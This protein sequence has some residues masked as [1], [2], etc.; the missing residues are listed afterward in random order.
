MDAQNLLKGQVLEGLIETVFKRARYQVVP[1]G[2]EHQFPDI[3]ALTFSEYQENLPEGLKMLPDFMVYRWSSDIPKVFF[4]EVKYRTRLTKQSVSDLIERL[5]RQ[6]DY[7]IDTYCI[8]AVAEPPSLSK[9]GKV[10]PYHQNHFRVFD[11][12]DLANHPRDVKK[13]WFSG[14]ALDSVFPEFD[15]FC[16]RNPLAEEMDAAYA[17]GLQPLLDDAVKV[18]KALGDIKSR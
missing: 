7:W 2:V 4:I 11:L 1:L 13:F 14:K 3:D 17:M 15:S 6:K 5:E 12:R 10:S 18:V 9:S 16:Q 8:L